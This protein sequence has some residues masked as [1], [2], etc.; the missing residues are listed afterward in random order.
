MREQLRTAQTHVCSF[1]DHKTLTLRI[2]LPLLG[3]ERGRGYWSLRPHLLTDDNIVDFQYRWQYWTRQR[4]N[5][6]SWLEWW[7][8]YAKPKI[9]SFFKWK[10]R[11][12]F[13]DFHNE[14]QRLYAELRLAYDGYYQHPTMLT[15]INRLKGEMLA[16]Q[17]NFSH[18]FMRA[19]ETHV[20]GEA[21]SMFQL[22]ER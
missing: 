10:S 19:N 1:S 16:L 8:S 22:G 14:H 18:M 5:Y 12:A 11:L 17:R 7:L 3:H 21:I 6:R 15:T 9:K 4:R 20:A 2:C 13:D